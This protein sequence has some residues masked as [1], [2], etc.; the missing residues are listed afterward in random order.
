M[1]TFLLVSL[2]TKGLIFSIEMSFFFFLL[3]WQSLIPLLRISPE[4]ESE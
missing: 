1:S 2:E 3:F 4:L